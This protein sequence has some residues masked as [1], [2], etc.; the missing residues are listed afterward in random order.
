MKAMPQS[1]KALTLVGDVYAAHQDGR[2][3][4]TIEL[5]CCKEYQADKSD[6]GF[7]QRQGSEIF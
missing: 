4:V 1:A 5:N 7:L 3:K 2:D 6:Q